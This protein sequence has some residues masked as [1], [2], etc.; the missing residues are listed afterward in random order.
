MKLASRINLIIRRIHLYSGI[1]LLPW[2]LMY[3]I[4]G[5][6]FN[7][8]G[9]FPRMQI[10]PVD[11]QMSSAT[12]MNEFPDANQLASR[13]VDAIQKD[14][15]SARIKLSRNATL[16]SQTISRSKSSRTDSNTSSTSI[17]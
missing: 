12:E 14:V 15:D 7:H 9:L 2:V 13:V 10:Q 5:A 6:M 16:N 17:L 11:A 4:T 3:G 8:L 1:F